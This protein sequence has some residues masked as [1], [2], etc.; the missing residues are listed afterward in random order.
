MVGPA[1][2]RQ[3]FFLLFFFNL[4]SFYTRRRENKENGE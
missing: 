4:F 3:T 1:L 2:L